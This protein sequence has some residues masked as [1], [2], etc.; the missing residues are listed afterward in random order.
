MEVFWQDI[1]YGARTLLKSPGFTLVAVLTLA[2]GIGVTTAIFS[3]VNFVLLRPLN[4]AN[5]DQLVMIW[6]RNLKKGWSESPNSFGNF[7][8]FR[9]SAKSVDVAAFTDTNF[10]VTGGEQ[11]ERV[12]GLRVSANLFSM[13]GVN[14][15]R[16][17]WFAPQEDKPGAGHVL[18]LS[19]GLWQRSFGGNPNLVNQTVQ[20]NGQ[21]YTVIGVMPPTFKFP[22]SF[23]A[24]VV[25]SEETVTNADLWVPL[26]TD[27]VPLVR[28]IRNLKMIG[29]LKPGVTAPQAQAEIN[30]IASRLDKEYPDVN[31]GIESHVIP[32]HEQVT[33]DIRLALLVLMAA[34]GFVLL[35][36]CA[37]VA[38]LLLAK[39]TSRQKEVAIR[40]AIG[41]NR[42]RILRQLLTESILLGLL[43]GLLGLLF[44]IVGTKSLIA[45]VTADIPRLKDFSFDSKVL[46]FTLAISL[47]TSLVFGLVPAIDA[48]NPNLNEALKEGGRSSGGGSGRNRLRSFLVIAEV[49]LA[50]VLVTAS[51]L[52][53]RSF[54]RLQRV[55]PGFNPEN[56]VT[57]EIELPEAPYRAEQQQRVFQQ[58]LLQ[59]IQS[60]PGVQYASTVDNLPFSGNANISSF[61][62]E[63][64]PIP[65]A[66]ER[67]RAFYRVISP[68]YFSTMG[69]PLSRG[70]QF[71]DRDSADVPGAAIINDAA[72]RKYWPGEDPLGK[73]IKRGRPESKNPWLTI[74]GTV[75]SANQLSLREDTQPEIYVP[76]LQNTSRTFT[77]AARTSSD[78]RTLAGSIRKEVWAIDKELPVSNMKLMD[79]LISNSVAQP[80][81]YVILLSVFAGLALILAAVGVY[82]VMSYSV[83]LRT[84][85]IGIRMALGAKPVDIFK[86][87][88][89]QALML[90]LIGLGIGIIL[91]IASTRLMSS[92][93]YGINATDPVTLGATS[94]VLLAVALLASYI[95]ARRATKVDPMVTLR[96]E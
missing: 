36:A 60:I 83:T 43:G 49:A 65:A 96:Y 25:G 33:G 22:P 76:Y 77:L 5:P 55:N 81:F 42:L 50:V 53:F 88:I 1:R 7:V 23:S 41:A 63:G 46:L 17:R 93:L 68:D 52:M 95:P 66:T 61:T 56:V 47:L 79:E 86:H 44:A 78:P 29:R 37:N 14:P 32:L 58:Q 75:G 38:N 13:L 57:L 3:V 73:R 35:I 90:G 62:I 16:G 18:I 94:L 2:L 24:T 27:D 82:G 34:V 26:T 31:S 69:I 64:R 67:P 9:D 48:S 6:E 84:R 54:V 89:G 72:V 51:G 85:D 59:K 92:L 28:D 30:A 91:A 21:S 74:V 19:Y 15:L 45:F 4:Y 80:R 40:T 70:N 20:V 71:T 12:A 10:N 39:A 8:D 11:P 87:V